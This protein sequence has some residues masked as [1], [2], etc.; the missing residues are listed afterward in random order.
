M[1]IQEFA[2]MLDGRES[3]NEI[4]CEEIEQAKELGFV[5]V[6]GYSDDNAELQ[7]AIRDEISCFEGGEIRLD[8]NGVFEE[9]DCECSH[10]VLAKE[11]CKLIDIRWDDSEGEYAWTYETEIP[12]ATFDVLDEGGNKWC[13]GIVFDIKSLEEAKC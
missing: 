12:H 5:V 6:C 9:C 3:G 11:K 13:R 1:A 7:G 2:K 8:S 10:S 4:T